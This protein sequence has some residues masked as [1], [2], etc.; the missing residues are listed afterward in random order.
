MSETVR[1]S[2]FASIAN[3]VFNSVS[4]NATAI[5][6]I[7][8]GGAVINATSL[9]AATNTFTVG[10]TAYF[11]ANGNV[12]FGT[13]SPAERLHIAGDIRLQQTIPEIKLVSE[14]NVNRW[15]IGANIS[16]SVNGGLHF[17][18]GTDVASGTLRMIIDSSG[19]VGIGTSSPATRL[20]VNGTIWSRGGVGGEGGELV[21]YNP[22]TITAGAVLDVSI[23]DLTRWFTTRNNTT[24]QIGQLGGTGGRI[25]FYT[26]GTERMR[27]DASGNV[28][29]GTS[30]P[31]SAR[32]N[33]AGF[34]FISGDFTIERAN[35]RIR[36]NN[37]AGTFTTLLTAVDSGGVGIITETNSFLYFS[38][39]NIERARITADGLFQ[40]NNGYGSV[41]TVFG[42]RAWVRFNGQATPVSINGSGGVS[43]VT[44]LANGVYRVNWSFTFPDTNYA[45]T[46]AMGDISGVGDEHALVTGYNPT[47]VQINTAHTGDNWADAAD[48]CLAAFR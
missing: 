12:G 6:G 15:Y 18:N 21:L 11:V 8:V 48:V 45:V 43:S 28:G 19:N 46:F 41:A 30:N 31:G 1:L 9:S 20:D 16:D 25:E 26:A 13:S 22:D 17:G 24:H 29:I 23:A 37:T 33:V 7:S 10:T 3:A 2:N 42:C 40:F 44:E 32:L 47:N 38:T 14:S 35:P 4:A 39:N 34:T 36:F 5:T 27:I